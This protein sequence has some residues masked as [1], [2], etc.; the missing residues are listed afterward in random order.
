MPEKIQVR[1]GKDRPKPTSNEK[2]GNDRQLPGGRHDPARGMIGAE[3]DQRIESPETD[4]AGDDPEWPAGEE[5]AQRR[6]QSRPA[7]K[8]QQT[9]QQEQHHV[10]IAQRSRPYPVAAL[11][12]HHPVQNEGRTEEQARKK[13]DGDQ[14]QQSNDC[15]STRRPA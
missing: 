12:A 2:G 4:A 11:Q 3:A 15:S 10:G 1:Q 7:L 14:F 13:S 9:A 6:R 8:E 5:Q